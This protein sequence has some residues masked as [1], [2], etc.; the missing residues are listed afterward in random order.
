MRLRTAS[1]TAYSLGAV[2]IAV[3]VIDH[4][5]SNHTAR[6]VDS[7]KRARTAKRPAPSVSAT[8]PAFMDVDRMAQFVEFDRIHEA[9]AAITDMGNCLPRVGVR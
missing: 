8:K 3:A 4:V 5:P 9:H 2:H 1:A 6:A 7:V